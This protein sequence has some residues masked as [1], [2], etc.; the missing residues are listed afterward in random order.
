MSPWAG[1]DNR[2]DPEAR[3]CRVRYVLLV[4]QRGSRGTKR[5]G[6]GLPGNRGGVA[7]CI[8]PVQCRSSGR[9][10]HPTLAYRPDRRASYWGA[11]HDERDGHGP[12]TAPL[13]TLLP[14][15]VP[16]LNAGGSHSQLIPTI[17]PADQSTV[18]QVAKETAGEK[19]HV[20]AG[21]DATADERHEHQLRNDEDQDAVEHS[22]R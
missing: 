17:D 19:L 7:A 1:L 18:D 9:L 16:L 2:V 4:C 14:W 13:L 12:A 21:E 3:H 5:L 11:A 15:A 10:S 6:G 20:S 22:P 8:Y